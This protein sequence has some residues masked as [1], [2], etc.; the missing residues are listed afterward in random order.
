MD[1]ITSSRTTFFSFVNKCNE[2]YR[3][4]HELELYKELIY[5][6]RNCGDI[7][8]LIENDIFLKKIYE[9]LRKWN[10]DQRGAR[11]APVDDFMKS[12]RLMKDSL[13]KLYE[14]KLYGDMGKDILIIKALLKK[15]FCNLKIMESNRRI[16]GVSKA[17]HFLLPDLIMPIDGKFTMAA[18]FGY[19]K[20]STSLDEEF[21]TFWK[22][23]K[24][25]IEITERLE[26]DPNDVDGVQWNTSVPKLIDNAIIGLIK[27]E[28]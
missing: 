15:V 22:I 3:S 28:K 20:Y 5:M 4:G 8:R 17:L 12:I 25:T 6:H 14:Y 19:N 26:L 16:V 24:E 7:E 9:T 1:R 27:S 18:F 10:M 2:Y 23:F 13:I 11:L 21:A